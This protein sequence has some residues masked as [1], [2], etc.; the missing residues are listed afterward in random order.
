MTN[1]LP[2]PPYRSLRASVVG[3]VTWMVSARWLIKGLGLVSTLILVRL[4]DPSDFGVVA[5]ANLVIGFTQ[6]FFSL[7]VATALIQNPNADESHFNT[8]WTI[9]VLQSLF[10]TVLLIL[11]SPVV[12]MYYHEPRVPL[13]MQVLAVGILIGGISNIG[14]V[15]FRKNLDFRSEFRLVAFR[16]I[17]SF[18]PTVALAFLLKSYWALV[19]GTV[20]GTAGGVLI[21]YAMHPF[22]PRWSLQRFNEIWHFSQWLLVVNLGNYTYGRTDQ[23]IVGRILTTSGMGVYA[24]GAEV[25]ELPVLEMTAPI[26]RVVMPSYAKVKHDA[27]QLKDAYLRVLGVTAALAFPI[28]AGVACIADSVVHLALGGKWLAAIPIIQWLVI[29]AGVRAIYGGAGSLM[30]ILGHMRELALLHWME[31]LCLVIAAVSGA[32]M[33]G[34]EGVAMAKVAVSSVFGVIFFGR[35]VS[36]RTVSAREITRQFLRPAL[37]TAIMVIGLSVLF[38]GT[39]GWSN[40]ALLAAKVAL[41]VVLYVGSL[42][43]VWVLRGKP[44]GAEEDLVGIVRERLELLRFARR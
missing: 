21:S 28:T 39:A 32:T 16:K 17:V 1:E 44:S 30:V 40:G 4:L 34:L 23:F 10:V 41:G 15:A 9:G 22:R 5:M 35:L 3:G 8:A 26:S 19:L 18:V 12:G 2:S 27:D 6:M 33:L 29:S 38:P 20:I 36:H 25:A 24:V 43:G 42:L 13:V 7:G 11:L 14:V 37:A 31:V